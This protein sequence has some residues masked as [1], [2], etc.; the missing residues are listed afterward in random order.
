MIEGHLI[1]IG[2]MKAGTTT[3]YELLSRHPD[4]V[5]GVRKELDYFAGR[6]WQG[7]NGY[8]G[9]FK[10]VPTDRPVLTLDASPAYAKKVGGSASPGRIAQMP[11]PVHLVYL[12]RDPV[13]RAVSH[14]RHNLRKGRMTL[15]EVSSE[16][17]RRYAQASRYS[18]RIRAYEAEGLGN[19]LMLLDFETLC[20]DPGEAVA[21][22]C[23]HAGLAPLDVADPVHA[24]RND[25]Q[26]EVVEN[27]DLDI[28]R[29][30]LRGERHRMIRRGFEPAR[31]WERLAPPREEPRA[32]RRSRRRSTA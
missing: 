29:S 9:Q 11:R 19:R 13:A 20:R 10:N 21:R 16:N 17:L 28:I 12:L 8:D 5:R 24:N 26:P 23:R 30:M 1:V 31:G 4:L 6:R 14:L 18:E 32:K 25:A 22:V 7:P 2:A 27:L 15:S 3:L